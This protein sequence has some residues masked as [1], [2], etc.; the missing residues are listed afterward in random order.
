MRDIVH[1]CL[2]PYK[3]LMSLYKKDIS[4]LKY[5]LSKE[6]RQGITMSI[7]IT[8]KEYE[9]YVNSKQKRGRLPQKKTRALLAE[10]G[11]NLLDKVCKRTKLIT[12]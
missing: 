10:N 8:R 9:D 5:A 3:R 2:E 1:L 11:R 7:L 4:E 12:A 6:Y